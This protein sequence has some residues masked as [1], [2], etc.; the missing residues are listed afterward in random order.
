MTR[1]LSAL[2]AAALLALAAVVAGCGNQPST[3][4]RTTLSEVMPDLSGA[5]PRLKKI[6]AQASQI[7]PG[8]EQAFDARLESL[9][10]IPVVANKWAS[11][12]HPCIAEAPAFQ[13]TAKK[14]GN[15]IAFLGVDVYDSNANAKQ[16]LGKF[17]QPY[18]SYSDPN[19]KISKQFP[20]PGSPPVTNFYDA[21][22]KL[23]HTEA[24]QV[25]SAA[26]LQSLIARYLD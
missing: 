11:W 19:M 24:G 17:P 7:L 8:G 3:A 10:G 6:G 2:A 13:Q 12:C 25:E 16:F 4:Q 23:V 5:D 20:P 21:A 1:T 15:K 14:L 26:E 9:R 18:P 22:G